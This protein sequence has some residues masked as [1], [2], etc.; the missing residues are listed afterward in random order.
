MRWPDSYAPGRNLV[1]DAGRSG[2]GKCFWRRSLVPGAPN[3][4]DYVPQHYR[5]RASQLVRMRSGPS[6]G[7]PFARP[8]NPGDKAPRPG[9]DCFAAARMRDLQTEVGTPPTL[10]AI[11]KEGR[12]GL[13]RARGKASP[14]DLVRG[15]P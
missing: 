2:I 10:L 7:R 11:I 6:R 14:P 1:S 3:R 13:S 15:P 8:P 5:V 9:G 12:R 4:E